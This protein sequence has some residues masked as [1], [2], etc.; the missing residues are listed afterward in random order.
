MTTLIFRQTLRNCLNQKCPKVTVN[1]IHENFG[2]VWIRISVGSQRDDVISVQVE[3]PA[4]VHGTME[5]FIIYGRLKHGHDFVVN[6]DKDSSI[7]AE[8]KLSVDIVPSGGRHRQFSVFILHAASKVAVGRADRPVLD[9]YEARY[10]QVYVIKGKG[11]HSLR[12]SENLILT[13]PNTPRY[14]TPLPAGHYESKE[15]DFP[16][17]I[18]RV[19]NFCR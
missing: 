5:V 16:R 8:V 4:S 10:K 9:H 6:F 14:P 12:I 18:N 19:T 7:V 1:G 17:L 13:L 3:N 2:A 11:D 15:H